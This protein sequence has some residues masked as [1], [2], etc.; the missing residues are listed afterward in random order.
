MLFVLFPFP[1]FYFQNHF[2]IDL[3]G[4]PLPAAEDACSLSPHDF[5]LSALPPSVASRPPVMLPKSL[6]LVANPPAPP[7][8]TAAA[9]HLF[10]STPKLECPQLDL[11]C[12][13]HLPPPTYTSPA[14][15]HQTPPRSVGSGTPPY[16][17]FTVNT[18]LL[19]S[20][21]VPLNSP[22]LIEKVAHTLGHNFT[23]AL[24]SRTPVG[25]NISFLVADAEGRTA[26]SQSYLVEEAVRGVCKYVS[27]LWCALACGGEMLEG[28]GRPGWRG[29]R[30]GP[31]APSVIAWCRRGPATHLSL[32]VANF[33]FFFSS[34]LTSRHSPLLPL[35]P[36]LPADLHPSTSTI[37]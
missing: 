37:G 31:R 6:P 32:S 21:P 17:L 11:F 26:L 8:I 18:T 34:R 15:A 16:T 35:P 33:V 5:V 7:F 36:L 28:E 22:T 9:G 14:S 1:S 10:R 2:L 23:V 13:F 12:S 27:L 24:G 3:E 4:S 30:L 20:L 25:T 29:S 19:T